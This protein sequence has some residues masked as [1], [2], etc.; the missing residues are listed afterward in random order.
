MKLWVLSDLHLFHARIIEYCSRPFVDV[1]SMNT[2][3]LQEWN[4]RVITDDIGIIVGDMSAGLGDQRSQYGTLLKQFNGRKILLRGNHDHEPD[5]FY[6]ANGFQAVREHLHLA[7]VVFHHF[8]PSDDRKDNR[9][10]PYGVRCALRY[11]DVYKPWAFLHGHDH[12]VD[13]PERPGCFNCASD[14]LGHV[15]IPLFDALFKVDQQLAQQRIGH[16]EAGLADLVRGS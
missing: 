10:V 1:A 9:S 16:I 2:H 13:V 4:A 11:L 6:L 8:P 12:R 5:D 15:P 3:L 7:G 14:R